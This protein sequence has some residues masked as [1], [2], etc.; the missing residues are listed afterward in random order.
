MRMP[1]LAAVLGLAA[2]TSAVAQEAVADW[3]VINDPS[4]K[5]LTASTTFDN[6]ITIGLRC[7]DGRYDALIAGLPPAAETA[8]MRSM[9]L[10]FGDDEAQVRDWYVSVDRAVAVSDLPARLARQLREGGVLHLRVREAGEGGRRLRYDLDL[11]ASTAQIDST[12]T[13]CNRPTT[14]PRDTQLA[15]LETTGLPG[16]VDWDVPPRPAYPR[17]MTYDRGFAA[18]TC[19]A[20]ADGSLSDCA[21]ES[22]YP[23]DGGFGREALSSTRHARLRN[24][25]TPGAA[26]EPRMIVYRTVFRKEGRRYDVQTGSRIPQGE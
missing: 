15:G 21:I 4:R 10:Q 7:M 26:I 2:T 6:G 23:L 3:D 25:T 16:S 12:L 8:V 11:P 13:A 9:S 22:E 5:L 18:V 19:I 14:D 1:I 20:R 24:T 17:G